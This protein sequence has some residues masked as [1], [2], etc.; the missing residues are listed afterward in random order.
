MAVRFLLAFALRDEKKIAL[1]IFHTEVND[2]NW[3]NFLSTRYL[4]KG[5]LEFRNV[6]IKINYCFIIIQTYMYL[7]L[8]TKLFF[9]ELVIGVGPFC[10]IS[11]T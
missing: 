5:T 4:E 11:L 7:L 3:L 1:H 6:G 9:L 8:D 10:I 2:E